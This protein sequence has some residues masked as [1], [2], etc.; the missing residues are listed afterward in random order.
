MS[1]DEGGTYKYVLLRMQSPESSDCSRLLV[2]GSQQAGYHRDVVH[3]AE[4]EVHGGEKAQV[5]FA[6][7]QMI[8][9]VSCSLLQECE[10]G[11]KRPAPAEV[12]QLR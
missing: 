8:S 11:S 4:E 6:L 1:I 2:R 12:Q 5:R 9:Q 10:V 7:I 3:S